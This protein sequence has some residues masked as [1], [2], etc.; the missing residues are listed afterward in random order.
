MPPQ[1]PPP[2]LNNGGMSNQ[3]SKHS[4]IIKQL[5]IVPKN[6]FK[7]LQAFGRHQTLKIV[8]YFLFIWLSLKL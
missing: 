6:H 4:V 3:H 1:G 7:K 5:K 2:G 8:K